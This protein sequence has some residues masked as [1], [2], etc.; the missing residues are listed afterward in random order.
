MKDKL[1]AERDR[2][3][4]LAMKTR[5]EEMVLDQDDLPDEMDLASSEYNQAIAFRLRGREKHLLSKIEEALGR[6]ET[7]VYGYC[8]VCEEPIG[9]ARLR[10]R[11][12]ATYCISCKEEQERREKDYS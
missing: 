3:I 5:K 9:D 11:P 1:A 4:S 8:E 12:V 2:I 6:I 7:G 10:A